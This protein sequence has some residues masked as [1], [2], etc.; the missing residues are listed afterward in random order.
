LPKERTCSADALILDLEDAVS[1]P[2]KPVAREM[3]AEYIARR[4]YA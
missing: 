2:R 1:G 3:A 4:A